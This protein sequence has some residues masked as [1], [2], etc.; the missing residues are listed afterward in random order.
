MHDFT[1]VPPECEGRG[2]C[3][4]PKYAIALFIGFYVVCTFIFVNLFTVV[5]IYAYRL[6]RD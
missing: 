3:G 5:R 2:D 6:S 4:S 1:V